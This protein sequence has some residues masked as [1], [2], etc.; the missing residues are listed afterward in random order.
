MVNRLLLGW[1]QLV[2]GFMLAYSLSYI[3]FFILLS[4]ILNQL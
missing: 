3:D 4:L 2:P 1:A